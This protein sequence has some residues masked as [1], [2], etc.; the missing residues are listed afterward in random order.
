MLRIQ[1]SGSINRL[2][3][4]PGILGYDRGKVM[5]LRTGKVAK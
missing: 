4:V 3:P 2:A 1:R 5:D